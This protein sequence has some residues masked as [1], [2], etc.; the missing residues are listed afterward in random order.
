M[1]EIDV[2]SNSRLKF[3]T[4]LL[5]RWLFINITKLKNS[6]CKKYNSPSPPGWQQAPPTW[7][8]REASME[9]LVQSA[10]VDQQVERVECSLLLEA[11]PGTIED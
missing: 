4:I 10:Q 6:T 1:L 3:L 11:S 2:N 9:D 5:K 8:C 7:V